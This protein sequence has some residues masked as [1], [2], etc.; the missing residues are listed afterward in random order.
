[1]STFLT[2]RTQRVNEYIS[3]GEFPVKFIKFGDTVNMV[4]RLG[5]GAL[6]AK[7]DV[8]YAFRLLPVH[9]DDRDLLGTCWVGLYFAELRLPVGGRISIYIFNSFAEKL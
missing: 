7:I 9:P 1:M 4:S 8:K 5:K 6:M 2:C 3:K